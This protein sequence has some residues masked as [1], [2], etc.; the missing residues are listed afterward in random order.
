MVC[1]RRHTAVRPQFARYTG[2]KYQDRSTVWFE[3]DAH[4]SGDQFVCHLPLTYVD[5][6]PHDRYTGAKTRYTVAQLVRAFLLK[7]L[8]GW[9]HETALVKYL[10]QYP[11]LCQELGFDSIPDQSTL[12]RSWQQRFTPELRGTIASSARTILI[13]A[14]D[15]GI[16][17]PR[18]PPDTSL[19]EETRTGTSPDEQLVLEHAE[20][21]TD[22]VGRIVY[23]AFSLDRGQ[24]C[25]IHTD[26]FWDLQ[27]YL[28]LREN[29]TA[30]EG[31]KV[32]SMNRLGSEHH[33][34]MLTERISA[35]YLSKGFARYIETRL[36]GSSTR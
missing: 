26:A 10:Q 36:S 16:A 11:S 6:Q 8:H 4:E 24:S 31:A 15:A 17:I 13:K 20:E 18:Q 32:S 30:N 19:L 2:R 27:A 22:H 33:S 34:D 7:E 3:H 1:L 29:L 28:G 5:F 23:P 9:S 35:A 21:I 12:W 25:K 14:D